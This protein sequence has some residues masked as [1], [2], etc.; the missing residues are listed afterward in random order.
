[1]KLRKLVVLGA[2]ALVAGVGLAVGAENSYADST[3][4]F[5]VSG[6]E[7]QVGLNEQKT[8]LPIYERQQRPTWPWY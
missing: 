5:E 1:M 8:S 7:Q 2:A 6:L 4:T 3:V